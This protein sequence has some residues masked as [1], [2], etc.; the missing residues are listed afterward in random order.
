MEQDLKQYAK[1]IGE[2]IKLLRTEKGFSREELADHVG[3]S[4]LTIGQIERGE[5]N[6]TVTVLWKI[7]S[8]LAVPFAALLHIEHEVEISRVN[9]S[10]KL[11]D[12]HEV[13]TVEPTFQLYNARSL[14]MYRAVIR[15]DSMYEADSH[16]TGVYEYVTVLSGRLLMKIGETSYLI[17]PS[18]TIKFHA[19]QPHCYINE[20]LD[21]PLVLQISI[22]YQ[23]P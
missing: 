6:P 11:T 23:A 15:Q 1:Q 18:E 17:H 16:S 20:S 2:K 19:N 14:E 21:E 5:G 22:S 13:F 3:V 4:K 8:G 7:A 9:D 12:E 10:M